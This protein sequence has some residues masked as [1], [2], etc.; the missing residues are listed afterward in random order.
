MGEDNTT[1]MEP[2]ICC[3]LTE[4]EGDSAEKANRVTD[5]SL[6]EKLGSETRRKRFRGI[7]NNSLTCSCHDLLLQ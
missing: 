5:V 2:C 1:E 6:G 7:I 3:T 4:Y